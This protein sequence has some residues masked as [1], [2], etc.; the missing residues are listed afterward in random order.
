MVT[1]FDLLGTMPR[2]FPHR[3][4]PFDAEGTIGELSRDG[5]AGLG[6]FWERR[7]GLSRILNYREG[8]RLPSTRLSVVRAK[9][10]K[11]RSLVGRGKRVPRISRLRTAGAPIRPSVTFFF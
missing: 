5:D 9:S 1:R 10:R 6:D 11:L 7:C 3:S 4:D 8:P 2:L